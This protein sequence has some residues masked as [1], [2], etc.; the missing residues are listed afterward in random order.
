ML[1]LNNTLWEVF[2]RGLLK[3]GL[4]AK[5]ISKVGAYL[6]VGVYSMIYGMSEML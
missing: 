2:S 5:M 3:G 1:P 4:S 6:E